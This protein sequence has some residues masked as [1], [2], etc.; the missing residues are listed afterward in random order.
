M[1]AK[2]EGLLFIR[3][4][5]HQ[6]LIKKGSMSNYSFS[7][8]D[9][10]KNGLLDVLFE[11]TEYPIQ[12]KELICY[13]SNEL[14]ITEEN[15]REYIDRFLNLEI[16]LDEDRSF[17]NKEILLIHNSA[18]SSEIEKTFG[19]SN[20]NLKYK[21]IILD[22]PDFSSEVTDQTIEDSISASDIFVI[23]CSYFSPDLFYKWNQKCIEL[24]KALVISYLDGNEGIVVPLMSPATSGCYNDFEILRESSFHNLLDYQLMKEK[25]IKERDPKTNYNELYAK[26]LLINTMLIIRGCLA[27]SKINQYAYSFDYERMVTTKTRLIRFPNCPSCQG[28]ANISHPFI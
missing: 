21:R 1:I 6:Y 27:N 23:V 5:K 14:S 24:N 25:L 13:L 19:V 28:D 8:Q 10:D 20:D 17:G 2:N 15:A 3:C 9:E 26:A 11:K 16:L 7:V 4:T 12:K 18:L 22:N